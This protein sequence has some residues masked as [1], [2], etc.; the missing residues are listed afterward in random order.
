[1][2]Y[3]IKSLYE[4]TT[5]KIKLDND[6]CT[7]TIA[8]NQGL[9][10]GCGFSPLLFII[11]LDKAIQEW[12]EAAPQGIQIDKH[13]RLNTTIFADD[14]VLFAETQDELQRSVFRLGPTEYFK[15]LQ[16]ENI[17]RKN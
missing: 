13:T 16:H 7:D 1:M 15:I 11:Y 3:S 6:K 14:Q 2:L 5:I 12:K 10:Q 8:T 9:R 4:T 17:S